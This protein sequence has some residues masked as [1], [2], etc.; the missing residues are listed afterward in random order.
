MG[1]RANWRTGG[2][3]ASD[4]NNNNNNWMDAKHN[5]AEADNNKHFSANLAASCSLVVLLCAGL[6]SPVRRL[7]PAARRLLSPVFM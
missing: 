3:E 6:L 2:D 7:F 5:T 4:E 1:G